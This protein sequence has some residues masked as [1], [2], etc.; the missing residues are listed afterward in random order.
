MPLHYGVYHLALSMHLLPAT[1][2]LLL[3][4]SKLP[5]QKYFDSK[6]PKSTLQ[7]LLLTY[8][9][10]KRKSLLIHGFF[11]AQIKFF[12][13]KPPDC[14]TGLLIIWGVSHVKNLL[15]SKPMLQYGV[16]LHYKLLT[17]KMAS[18]DGKLDAL[19]VNK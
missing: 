19:W 12:L 11:P 5:R 17:T 15:F 16:Q 1:K 10:C 7:A 6:V 13:Q 9:S 3:F 8:S 18:H 14:I 2:Q 4:M